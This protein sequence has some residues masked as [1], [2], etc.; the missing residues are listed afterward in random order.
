MDL[1]EVIAPYAPAMEKVEEV[2]R[3]VEERAQSPVKEILAYLNHRSGKRLRPLL[4]IISSSS[5][6]ITGSAPF[7]FVAVLHQA[8]QQEKWRLY[9][10]F[11]LHHEY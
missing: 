5:F 11:S 9:C 8:S 2:I 1:E 3:R 4:V 10:T 6:D 7:L